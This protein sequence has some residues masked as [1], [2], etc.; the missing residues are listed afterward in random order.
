MPHEEFARPPRV[1][2]WFLNLFVPYEQAEAITGD[3]LE[4]FSDVASKSGLAGAKQWY[5]RQS[6]RTILHFFAAGLRGAPWRT[7][8]AV[9]GGLLFIFLVLPQLLSSL[10]SHAF[11]YSVA[12]NGR[13]VYRIVPYMVPWFL[14]TIQ[15]MTAAGLLVVGSAVAI[16]AR[17]REIGVTVLLFATNT[18]LFITRVAWLLSHT[19]YGQNWLRLIATFFGSTMIVVGGIL[20][21]MYRNAKARRP[22]AA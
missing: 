2:T 21:R 19:I 16:A 8:G 18:I 5:W 4:E 15:I 6:V 7:A 13:Q 22:L 11:I 20:V 17:G 12:I 3:L 14:T 1:A 10:I 9:S